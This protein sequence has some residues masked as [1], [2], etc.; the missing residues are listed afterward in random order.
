MLSVGVSVPSLVLSSLALGFRF[1][2]VA[3]DPD[4]GFVSKDAALV[5][6]DDAPDV[7]EDGVSYD[8]LLPGMASPGTARFACP[9]D[10]P[11]F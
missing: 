5:L 8:P 2:I 10:F 9:L 4:R 1:V 11:D 3:V 7:C 6:G